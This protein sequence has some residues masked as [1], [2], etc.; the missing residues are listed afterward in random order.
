[1]RL[2]QRVFF[3]SVG[4]LFLVVTC[5]SSVAGGGVDAEGNRRVAFQTSDR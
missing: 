2:G 5:G 3:S 1:M 4:L